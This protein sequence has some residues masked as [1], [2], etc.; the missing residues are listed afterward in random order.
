V[1]K[2]VKLPAG[3][4]TYRITGGCRLNAKKTIVIAPKKST[5][6]QF[7]VTG[8]VKTKKTTVRVNIRVL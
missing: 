5:T 2:L 3:K 1:T 6:C 4:R 8:N 7:T